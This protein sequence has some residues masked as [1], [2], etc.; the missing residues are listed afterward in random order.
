MSIDNLA[1]NTVMIDFH[2][3]IN[4]DYNYN[5]RGTIVCPITRYFP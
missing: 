4:R 1:I 5:K 2:S 3:I